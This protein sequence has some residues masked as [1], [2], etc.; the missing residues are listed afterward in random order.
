[1]S[2]YVPAST[3]FSGDISQ[4]VGSARPSR[5][6]APDG[7]RGR[8]LLAAAPA[9]DLKVTVAGVRVLVDGEPV[10]EIERSTEEA[11]AGSWA[12]WKGRYDGDG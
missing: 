2:A 3:P 5:G 7:G 6:H 11:I 9:F 12:A 10:L 8:E 1:M 4:R